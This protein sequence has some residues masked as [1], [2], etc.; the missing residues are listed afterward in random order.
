MNKLKF[1]H[2]K[3]LSVLLQLFPTSNPP[4]CIYVDTLENFRL[5]LGKKFK[6]HQQG[7]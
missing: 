4:P 7:N 2:V 1:S 3:P 5:H 6:N